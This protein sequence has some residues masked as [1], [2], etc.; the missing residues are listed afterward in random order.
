MLKKILL[1]L[2]AIISLLTACNIGSG[3]TSQNNESKITEDTIESMNNQQD[4]IYMLIGTYTGGD[5]NGIYVYALDTVTGLSR[6]ISET[7]ISNPSYLV[8]D[9]SE[10]FVY[11]VTEDDQIQT[12]SVSAF[13][14]NKEKGELTLIN[15]QLTG[16]EAPCHVNIDFSGKHLVVSNYIGGSLST[17]KISDDGSLNPATQSISFSGKGI[18]PER[19]EKSHIHYSQFSP[20]GKYL[21]A[22]DLGTDKI[23]KFDVGNIDTAQYLSISTPA[24]FKVADGS[25]PRHLAFHPNAK[26]VYLITELSG[27]VIVFDYSNGNLTQKQTIKADTLNAKGSADIHISPDGKFLYASNRLEGDGIAIFAINDN[28]GT[29]SKVAYQPT[30]KHPRNFAITPNG[31][32]LLVANRDSDLIQVFR[33]DS[34]TGLLENI[35]HDIEIGMPVCIQFASMK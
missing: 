25:G 24:S 3:K 26:Y 2:F 11:A 16:G 27:D 32:L 9:P 29:L 30:A 5:S 13:T 18:D 28:D 8:L 20:D 1:A 15:K 31:R 7:E 4:E 10:K 22:D 14:F 12:A 34:N 17:F 6:Y 21:F 33:R 19:Q 23:H 35:Q